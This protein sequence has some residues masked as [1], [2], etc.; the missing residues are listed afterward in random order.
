MD[1]ISKIEKRHMK[2]KIPTFKVGDEVE[3]HTVITEGEKERIQV[4]KG[5]I[6]KMKGSGLRKTFTVR[7]I[8]AGEG[9]ERTWPVHSPGIAKIRVV[10]AGKVRR[11]KLYYLRDRVGKGTRLKESVEETVRLNREARELEKA[12]SARIQEEQEKEQ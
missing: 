4:F 10:K 11:S 6:I 8:V 5:H 7:R 12:E 2:D 3:V 1:V 9:V